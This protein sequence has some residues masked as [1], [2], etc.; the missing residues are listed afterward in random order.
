LFGNSELIIKVVVWIYLVAFNCEKKNPMGKI[1][2]ILALI[3]SN[4]LFAQTWSFESGGNAF[5]GK[6][7]TASIIG[8]GNDYPYDK[9]LL[10]INFY[11]EES[12]NFYIADAGYYQSLSDIEILWVF[13]NEPNVLYK[14]YDFSISEDGKILFLDD[15]KN[16]ETGELL[17]KLEFIEKLKSASRVDVRIENKYGKNDIVF[18][19]N[20]ST[21]GIDFVISKKYK[22]EQIAYYNE[23]KRIAQEE[24]EKNGKINAKVYMLLYKAGIND[25]K[26]LTGI[27]EKIE[28]DC[29]LY[30]IKMSNIDSLNIKVDNYSF[31]NIDLFK[32]DGTLLKE[33]KYIETTIPKYVKDFKEKKSRNIQNKLEP[34]LLKYDLTELERNKIITE[35]LDQSESYNKFN[36]LDI[37]SLE[38]NTNV[39]VK[40]ITLDIFDVNNRRISDFRILLP[41]YLKRSM[42]ILKTK[43]LERLNGL[44]DKYNFN[45]QEKGKVIQNFGEETIQRIESGKA[46]RLEFNILQNETKI[47]IFRD[48]TYVADGS[49]YSKEFSKQLKKKF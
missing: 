26:E 46:N 31:A 34:F 48:K 45:Q 24:L 27:F 43:G 23:L 5:D 42:L 16:S 14:S 22:E 20:G 38:L 7:K 39:S 49:I 47:R 8:K 15:F 10:V 30:D 19:L 29:D 11:N 3:T 35:T 40:T 32:I 2:M 18:S 44:L 28:Y 9:P 25:D 6:Y 36:I 21:K 13:N 37:D 17:Y 12:L 41:E 4:V 1:I 33:I